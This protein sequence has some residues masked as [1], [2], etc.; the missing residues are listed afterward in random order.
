VRNLIARIPYP[1]LR[2]GLE[3][4]FTAPPILLLPGDGYAHPLFSPYPE[5]ETSY[6]LPH[7]QI[8]RIGAPPPYLSCYPPL[9]H[10]DIHHTDYFPGDRNPGRKSD[11]AD[12]HLQF[13]HRD[14]G[15]GTGS[16]LLSGGISLPGAIGTSLD[17]EIYPGGCL[18]AARNS[19]S[20]LKTSL[21]MR[22][23]RVTRKY[24]PL[25]SHIS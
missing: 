14:C 22:H 6:F 4:F 24:P 18:M 2:G 8:F 13:H 3:T 19:S 5:R 9:L 21:V 17:R 23:Y 10:P 20:M 16:D 7:H 15:P 1:R 25:P 12:P 11:Q